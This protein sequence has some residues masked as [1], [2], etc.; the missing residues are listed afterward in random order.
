MA[1]VKAS[2]GALY[3]LSVGDYIGKNNGLVVKIEANS[4]LVNELIRATDKNDWVP[5]QIRLQLKQ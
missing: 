1:Y 4:I 3:L 2:D 5:R